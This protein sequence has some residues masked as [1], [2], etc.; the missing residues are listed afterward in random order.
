MVCLYGSMVWWLWMDG[1]SGWC[2]RCVCLWLV[3]V[4]NPIGCMVWCVGV[5]VFRG[6][7]R[8][9]YACKRRCFLF[10]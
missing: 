1:L 3:W 5:A 9:R 10:C 8:W 6:G 2:S 4:D 7:E